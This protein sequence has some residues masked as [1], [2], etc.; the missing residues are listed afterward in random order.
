MPDGGKRSTKGETNMATKNGNKRPA[1]VWL[2]SFY[3]LLS[4]AWALLLFYLAYSGVI[5]LQTTQKQYFDN[6]T[7][8]DLFLTVL[9]GLCNLT[10]AVLIF[11]LRKSAFYVLAAA[12]ILNIFITIWHTISKGYAEAMGGI[13]W[14]LIGLLIPLGI[15]L[16]CWWLKTKGTLS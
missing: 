3:L 2:V 8:L 14:I 10:G 16:Y 1:L 5:S 9:L 11:L 12:L 6:L 4:T 13:S 15:C 7:S